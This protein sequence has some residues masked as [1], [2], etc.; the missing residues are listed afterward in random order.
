VAAA[1]P[2]IHAPERVDAQIVGYLVRVL[3]E[4]NTANDT[5]GPR[6]LIEVA[7]A[8]MR[9][10]NHLL[11]GARGEVRNKL[12]TVGAQYAEFAGWLH[13]VAGNAQA[14]TYWSDRA[15]ERA[16]E[17]GNDVWVSYVL[18]RKSNQTRDLHDADSVIGLAQAAQRTISPL[19]PRARAVA[20]QQEAQGHGLAGDELACHNLFDQALELVGLAERE[21]DPSPGRY[22]SEIYIELQRANCWLDLGHPLRAIDLFERQL[23]ILPVLYYTDRGIHLSRQAIAHAANQDPEQAVAVG[24]KALAISRETGS[25]RILTELHRLDTSLA[26][27]SDLAVVT[28]FHETLTAAEPRKGA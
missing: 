4:H 20:M 26:D 9:F 14:A 25:A 22:C 16:Q 28:K 18:M 12:L 21:Q 7:A 17:A 3:D 2:G 19:P 27:W 13:Q 10:V 15:M 11:R 6:H 8:Q 5:H 1:C 23:A 24:H